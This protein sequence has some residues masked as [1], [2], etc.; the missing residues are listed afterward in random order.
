M[1]Q[2][3]N[4]QQ[5]PQESQNPNE[6]VLTPE[7]DKQLQQIQ[8]ENQFKRGVGWFY[9][10]AGL[11]LV[12]SVM[13][14]TGAEWSFVIGLGATQLVDAIV[15]GITEE[16]DVSPILK[17][18]AFGIDLLIAGVY[19]LI[20]YLGLKR[21]VAIIIVGMVLYALDGLIFLLVGD[22]FSIAFHGFAL[23]CIFG[24]LKA[25][26]QLKQTRII[27]YQDDQD[28]SLMPEM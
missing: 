18:V 16:M 15:L 26:K 23:F 8:L 6:S 7:Q 13:W 10:I 28:R 3:F 2:M 17:V 25:L 20:G 14:L 12:N 9:W 21:I 5:S 24:G 27:Q 19:V 22:F 11:S 4:P 1:D